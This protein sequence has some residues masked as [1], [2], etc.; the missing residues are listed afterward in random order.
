MLAKFDRPRRWDS[1]ERRGPIL[2]YILA[3]TQRSRAENL[4]FVLQRPCH[5]HIAQGQWDSRKVKLITN[6]SK[7]KEFRHTHRQPSVCSLPCPTW[8]TRAHSEDEY[9]KFWSRAESRAPESLVEREWS[10]LFQKDATAHSHI[11]CPL[12]QYGNF[13]GDASAWTVQ[14]WVQTWTWKQNKTKI[15]SCVWVE[16]RILVH[17]ALGRTMLYSV[18]VPVSRVQRCPK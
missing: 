9:W 4:L 16:L 1:W 18:A 13:F 14:T 5:K 2:A 8:N 12:S 17:G 10:W 15:G 3:Q 7:S 11:E 6:I